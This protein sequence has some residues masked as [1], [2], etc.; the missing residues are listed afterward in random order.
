MRT[1]LAVCFICF[2][3]FLSAFREPVADLQ[4]RISNLRNTNGHVLVSLFRNG[5]GYP[6]QPEKSFR[7]GKA[8]IYGGNA[9]MLFTD[10]PA[11]DYAI[12]ILHDENDDL[13]MNKSWLGLPK[14]GYGFSNNVMGMFGPPDLDKASFTVAA[15]TDRLIQIRTRY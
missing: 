9:V 14:E 8:T 11:G 15:G 5:E 12:A 10:V 7:K 1:V 3:L 13:K 6:D 4:V 2:A